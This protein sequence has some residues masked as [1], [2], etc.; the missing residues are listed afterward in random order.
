MF[1]T[2][3][4]RA[5]L[6][7]T[8][9][10]LRC[11]STRGWRGHRPCA[12]GPYDEMVFRSMVL[13]GSRFYDPLGLAA[14][15]TKTDFQGRSQLVSLRHALHELPGRTPIRRSRCCD[16]SRGRTA[17]RRTT[18]PASARSTALPLRK[19]GS[20]W[21]AFERGFQAEEHR[22]D[23]AVPDY[24]VQGRLA[25]CTRLLSRAYVDPERARDLCRPELSR[26][27]GLHGCHQS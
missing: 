15:L 14:E 11:F 20:D 7:G 9:R 1:L 3:P 23:P 5:A 13:D 6:A 10:A 22:N 17:Q 16:G 26:N 25:R 21:I 18:R 4:R 27:G 8:W 24:T 12:Q 19:P 2:T